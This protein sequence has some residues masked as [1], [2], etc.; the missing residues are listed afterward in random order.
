MQFDA[1]LLQRYFIIFFS[2]SAA[3]CIQSVQAIANLQKIPRLTTKY[4]FQNDEL[5]FRSLL[6]IQLIQIFNIE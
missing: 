5:I 1:D 4:L 3:I 6:S 2:N